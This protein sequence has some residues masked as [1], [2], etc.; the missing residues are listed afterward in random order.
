MGTGAEGPQAAIELMADEFFL[1]LQ[2]AKKEAEGT[3]QS[4]QKILSSKTM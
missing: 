4:V 2:F 3:L 1:H